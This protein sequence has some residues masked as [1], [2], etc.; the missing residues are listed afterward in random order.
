VLRQPAVDKRQVHAEGVSGGALGRPVSCEKVEANGGCARRLLAKAGE[1]E[2]SEGQL[3]TWGGKGGG[4]IT[5]RGRHKEVGDCDIPPLSKGGQS[6]PGFV[7]G[8]N[9]KAL[10]HN[11]HIHGPNKELLHEFLSYKRGT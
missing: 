1:E 2:E 10:M 3:D 9:A 7:R 6:Q 11:T 5:D 8:V 4:P